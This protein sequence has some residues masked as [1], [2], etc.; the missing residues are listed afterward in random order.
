M[1]T[2]KINLHARVSVRLR[3]LSLPAQIDRQSDE[4]LSCATAQ[5]RI[6]N[7]TGRYLLLAC[8]RPL[9]LS[10]DNLRCYEM[11]R[12]HRVTRTRS[13][14]NSSNELSELAS[15]G[16]DSVPGKCQHHSLMSY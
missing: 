7:N 2:L 16:T 15:N 1:Q 14:A 13:L 5:S 12:L 11:T 4:M 9:V 10:S 3:K 6:E 8:A